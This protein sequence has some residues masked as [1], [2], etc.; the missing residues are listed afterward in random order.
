MA[1]NDVYLNINAASPASAVVAA[2]QTL[3]AAAF[4]DLVLGDAPLFNFYFT[5]GTA[6]WP[7]WAG[8]GG[9]TITWAL[10]W[11]VGGDDTPLAIQT[12]STPITGGWSMR[13]PVNTG[14]LINEMNGVRVSQ[15]FPVVRLW[16]QIRVADASGNPVSYALIRTNVRL[17]AIPDTQQVP[18]DPLPAGTRAV[19]AAANGALSSPSNFFSASGFRPGYNAQSNAIGN[20]AVAPGANAWLHTEIITI[21]GSGGTTRIAYLITA[22]RSAGDRCTV[23][24]LCPATAAITL[25]IRNAAAAGTVL[26]TTTTDGS[27][28][29]VV[30]EFYFDGAAWQPLEAQFAA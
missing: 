1:R 25:E 18:D 14:R 16:Q 17:R 12:S 30:A 5:D 24:F 21:S 9:Y 28:D 15:D 11:S 19:L 7:T 6:V 22:G 10:G 23:R 8:A 26:L 4:P 27:G 29:D 2:Q 3:T 20:S 13:L